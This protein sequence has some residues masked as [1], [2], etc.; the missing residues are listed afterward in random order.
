MGFPIL[1]RKTIN[2]DKGDRPIRLVVLGFVV[3]SIQGFPIAPHKVTRTA[4]GA[5]AQIIG[6][7]SKPHIFPAF[8]IHVIGQRCRPI[9]RHRLCD[10]T[11]GANPLWRFVLRTLHQNEIHP[12]LIGQRLSLG[13]ENIEQGNPLLTDGQGIPIHQNLIGGVNLIGVSQGLSQILEAHAQLY[14]P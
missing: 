4:T 10:R 2:E 7:I 8:I 14:W 9:D 6:S 3:A 5:K 13:T 1:G 12:I 11:A